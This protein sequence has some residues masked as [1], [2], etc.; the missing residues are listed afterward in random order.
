MSGTAG[1]GALGWEL[2]KAFQHVKEEDLYEVFAEEK[3]AMIAPL[4]DLA[5]RAGT[6]KP[7]TKAGE[8]RS[9]IDVLWEYGVGDLMKEAVHKEKNRILK[10]RWDP[11]AV[12]A[13]VN[14]RTVPRGAIRYARQV[15]GEGI[16]QN[17]LLPVEQE[18]TNLL[19]A[20]D[21]DNRG[22]IRKSGKFDKHFRALFE[23]LGGKKGV[24][25]FGFTEKQAGRWLGISA[26]ATLKYE[27]LPESGEITPEEVREFY[28]KD[29]FLQGLVETHVHTIECPLIGRGDDQRRLIKQIRNRILK[30]GP[31]LKAMRQ[32]FDKEATEH[33]GDDFKFLGGHRG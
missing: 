2:L 12:A 19:A 30:A 23:R 8:L 18:I 16:N 15:D 27:Q 1:E 17:G 6:V 26:L 29:P 20:L 10:N 31:D 24:D 5:R 3:S 11:E 21:T 28:E 33:S 32:A 13:V 25:G 4:V 7:D 14:G 9:I 22:E